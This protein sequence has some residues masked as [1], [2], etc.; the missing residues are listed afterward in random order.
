MSKIVHIS[1]TPKDFGEATKVMT[2]KLQHVIHPGECERIQ[3]KNGLG[4][5]GWHEYSDQLSKQGCQQ[6]SC[7]IC[8]KWC[9]EYERCYLFEPSMGFE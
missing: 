8:K 1:A 9:W 7:S 3:E 4:Y 2:Q 5:I 6:L